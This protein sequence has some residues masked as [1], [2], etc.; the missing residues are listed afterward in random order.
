MT[1]NL[2]V[3]ITGDGSTTLR[4]ADL[5]ETYH[6]MHGAVTESRHVFIHAGLEHWRSLFP[7]KS[8]LNVFEMGFGTGLNAA[9]TWQWAITTK[10]SVHYHSV[11]LYPLPVP[12]S[13]KL[14][15]PGIPTEQLSQLHQAVWSESFSPFENF[16]LKK[17]CVDIREASPEANS[18]DLIFYDAFAPSRQPDLWSA[19]LMHKMSDALAP[20]GVLVSYC[21]QGQFKRNLRDAGLVVESLPGPPGKREMVRAL[22]SVTEPGQI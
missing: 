14:S 11:E 8:S 4:N 15:F 6:S 18:I 1:G 13:E 9:L 10:I 19:T 22:K 21:A 7:H 20:G 2:T 5:Q 12:V 16:Y 17:E 3:E